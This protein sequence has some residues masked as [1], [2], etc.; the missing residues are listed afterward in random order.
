MTKTGQAKRERS[1]QTILLADGPRI[2]RDMLKRLIEKKAELRLVSDLEGLDRLPEEV[3][4]LRPDWVI[5]LSAS[6]HDQPGLIEDLI[7]D[8]SEMHIVILS[9]GED[10]TQLGW[11]EY[12]SEKVPNPTWEGL[13]RSLALERRTHGSHA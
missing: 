7:R 2:V 12:H 3:R 5:L 8:A 13:V 10:Q 1:Q 11:L 4:R 6:L 9:T